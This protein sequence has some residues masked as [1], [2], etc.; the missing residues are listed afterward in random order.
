M[1]SLVEG[2]IY[3]YL[4]ICIGLLAFNIL[5]ITRARRQAR[6]R[7]KRIKEWRHILVLSDPGRPLPE[8]LIRRLKRINNLTA[9]FNVANEH[10]SEEKADAH[11]FVTGNQPFFRTLAEAY[12]RKPAMERAFFAYMVATFYSYAGIRDHSMSELLLNYFPDSTV[13]SRENILN[14]LYVLG[15]ESAVEHAF[16]ILNEQHWYHHPK[17][18]SD[19]MV[20]FTG[21]QE[22][23]VRRLWAYRAQWEECL[24][25]G[26]VQFA[27][28]L[29]ENTFAEEYLEALEKEQLPLEVRFALLRYFQKHVYPPAKPVM[30]HF[31]AGEDAEDSQLAVV[32]VSELAAYPGEDTRTALVHALHDR[33]WYVR[34]NAATSLNRLGMTEEEKGAVRNSGDR[35]AVEMM[36]YILGTAGQQKSAA[37]AK[38]LTEVST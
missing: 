26:I 20:R 11:S 5:Y 27:A 17:L 12:G 21:D 10:F 28:L 29:P 34:R 16:S 14:A 1:I 31:L 8:S 38:I 6:R 25:L 15:S 19:G 32:A 3:F 13:Y 36:D 33:N 23:L 35:Y 30:L 7:E 9:F 18:L 37:T 4:F 24:L 22:A 2:L